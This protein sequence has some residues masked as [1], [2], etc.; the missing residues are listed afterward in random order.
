MNLVLRLNVLLVMPVMQP[1]LL[2]VVTL[3]LVFIIR[4]TRP[5]RMEIIYL[6]LKQLDLLRSAGQLYRLYL[7]IQQVINDIKPGVFTVTK[8]TLLKS[9]RFA[10]LD[11]KPIRFD[12]KYDALF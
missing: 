11:T 7:V 1:L 6:L 8:S 10:V 4:I 9:T 3:C 12:A 2:M 5:L